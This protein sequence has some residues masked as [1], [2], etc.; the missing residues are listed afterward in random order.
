MGAAE[1]E[2]YQQHM[3]TLNNRRDRMEMIKLIRMIRN[4]EAEFAIDLDKQVFTV[5]VGEY[6]HEFPLE[7][8][9]YGA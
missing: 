1:A 8:T 2:S 5:T 4:S 9:G 7:V 6:E 3:R